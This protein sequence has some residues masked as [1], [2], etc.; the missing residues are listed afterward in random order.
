MK[1]ENNQARQHVCLV[2]AIV[3]LMS[4]T[5]LV[6]G[7]ARRVSA[8]A[9]AAS[10]TFTGNLN[11]GR[12]SHTATLLPNGKV[13]VA[14]GNDSN[15]TLKSAELYDPVTGAWSNTG[16]LN[17]TRAFHTATL[18]L[19]GKV[20]IAGGFSC[21]PPFPSCSLTD[22][23]ELYDPATGTWSSTGSLNTGTGREDHTATLLPNGKVLLAG[24]FDIVAGDVVPLYDAEL[25][26][27]AT[28]TWSITGNLNT[29]RYRHT[30]SLLQNGKVLVA[31]GVGF[32]YPP[33]LNNAELYDPDTGRW[34]STGN[35]NTARDS[36]VGVLLPSGKILVA[37]GW[38]DSG[39]GTVTNSAELYDPTTGIWSL[40]G[41]LNTGR[42]YQAHSSA[43]TQKVE[44]FG[45]GL[46]DPKSYGWNVHRRIE[47]TNE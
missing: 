47:G 8:Q 35:L 18:L 6:L 46:P 9:G 25:Y 42:V 1:N 30:A 23:A 12:D 14:G 7:P 26:D 13:L 20:L 24:G 11:A 10:W 29:A 40:T 36:H 39:L 38:V 33:S 37:G 5:T 22:S 28:G 31:A 16:N 27:P 3:G 41:S 43:A 4:A 17:T 44:A 21:G 2:L 34:S 45:L 15:G 19:N 32:S